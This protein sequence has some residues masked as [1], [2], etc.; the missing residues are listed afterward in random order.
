M[1]QLGLVVGDE[2]LVGLPVHGSELDDLQQAVASGKGEAV[3]TAAGAQPHVAL[4]Q[5]VWNS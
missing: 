4:V 2:V 3:V 1:L 5:L